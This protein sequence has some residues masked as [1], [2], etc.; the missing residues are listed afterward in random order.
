MKSLS[1]RP[2][3]TAG[4]YCVR[5]LRVYFFPDGGR[6]IEAD[7]YTYS[8]NV[9]PEFQ[10]VSQKY[11]VKLTNQVNTAIK[12]IHVPASYRGVPASYRGVPASYR[13]VPT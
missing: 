6:F 13:G 10:H 5:P 8:V 11:S 7:T 2:A 1:F 4:H 3:S 9:A 12:N